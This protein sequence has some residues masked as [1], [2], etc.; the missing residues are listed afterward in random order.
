MKG[1]QVNKTDAWWVTCTRC[2]ET[3]LVYGSH[4]DI[5]AITWATEH[6]K[7]HAKEVTQS[8]G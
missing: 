7:E 2:E 5:D 1:F 6:A 8:C 3:E 4:A